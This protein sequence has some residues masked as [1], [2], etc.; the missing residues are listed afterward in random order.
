MSRKDEYSE[1]RDRRSKDL[2]DSGTSWG[3][4][5]GSLDYKRP[6]YRIAELLQEAI[7][8]GYSKREAK[9][10]AY[11]TRKYS[12]KLLDTI[13]QGRYNGVLAHLK[14]WK[15]GEL[16]TQRDWALSKLP[17]EVPTDT[18]ARIKNLENIANL[19][20]INL[21][22]TTIYEIIKYYSEDM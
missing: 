9:L 2:Y 21:G 11:A 1:R 7:E 19:V 20:S 3:F 10:I 12:A 14:L 15:S 4:Q 18:Q 13:M 8:H 17:G 6:G 5:D 16:P 22:L